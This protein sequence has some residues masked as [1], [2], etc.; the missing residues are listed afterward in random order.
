MQLSESEFTLS[1][2]IGQFISLASYQL[3]AKQARISSDFGSTGSYFVNDDKFSMLL[4]L[5][6]LRK[7]GNTHENKSVTL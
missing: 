6:S 5:A 4:I 1:A 3:P 7:L 2:N